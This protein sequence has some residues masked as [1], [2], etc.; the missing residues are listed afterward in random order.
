MNHYEEK[1]QQQDLEKVEEYLR[2]YLRDPGYGGAVGQILQD[3]E[4]SKGKRLRPRL[5][6][7]ASRYGKNDTANAPETR[8]RLCR[9]GALVEL[10]HMASLVHDDIVDPIYTARRHKNSIRMQ[11]IGRFLCQHIEPCFV[12]IADL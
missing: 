4:K 1:E 5:L 10:V 11:G 8:D 2:E 9:L 6:L 7:M 12:G 3:L